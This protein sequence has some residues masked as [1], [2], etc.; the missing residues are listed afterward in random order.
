MKLRVKGMSDEKPKK[1]KKSDLLDT[2]RM[3]G[4]ISRLNPDLWAKVEAEAEELGVPKHVLMMDALQKRY[5][6]LE[7][8]ASS[9]TV[10]QLIAAWSLY[11]RLQK[12]ALS[13]GLAM[14]TQ[15]IGQSFQGLVALIESMK[16][17]RE[18]SIEEEIKKRLASDESRQ[19]RLKLI[20]A[21]MPMLE[22]MMTNVMKQLAPAMAGIGGVKMPE[23]T[24]QE[25]E[26][27]IEFEEK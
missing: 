15:F 26:E 13:L 20:N 14:T 9:L 12:S 19:M 27:E 24:A 23:I 25:E 6:L 22:I 7:A 16:E 18:A 10:P 21:L 2:G 5:F 11:D 17:S 8:E 3:M 4:S 1:L